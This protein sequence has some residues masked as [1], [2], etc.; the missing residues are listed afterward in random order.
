MASSVSIELKGVDSLLSK[1]KLL[2]PRIR[3]ATEQA[4]AQTALLIETDAKLNAPVDTG[5]LRSSIHTEIAP[6]K[7]SAMV[8]DGVTYGVFLEY[9][10]RYIRGRPFLFPAYEK[11]RGAFVA[12]LK[13]KTKLF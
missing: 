3:A 10:T 4:V 11:N 13:A 9:G 2:V 12:L 1:V 8:L 5:R 7:L 6:N